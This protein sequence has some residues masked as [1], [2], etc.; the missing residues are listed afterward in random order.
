MIHLRADVGPADG[1]RIAVPD[2]WVEV[3][4]APETDVATTQVVTL[5]DWEPTQGLRPTMAVTIR[6]PGPEPVAMR[7]LVDAQARL[8]DVHVVSIDP[9]R[10]DGSPAVGRRLVFAHPA[11]DTTL[12]TLVWAVATDVGDVVVTAHADSTE[13]HR[14][15]AA[16]A[17]AVAGIRLPGA[18]ASSA[19]PAETADLARRA[20]GGLWEE[21][22]P[23]PR[24]PRAAI[25]ADPDA[26]ILVEAS[27]AGVGHRFDATLAGGEATVSATGSPRAD[28]RGSRV[29]PSAPP[30]TYRLPITRLGLAVA[31]WLGL[32]PAR[33]PSGDAV[34]LPIRLVMQRL[35]DPS[36][37]IPDGVD[38]A[39]WNQPWFLWTVRSSATD[40]GLVMVDTGTTGQC[41]VMETDDE[42]TTRF[43]PL[44][45]YN[46][47]L[48]LNWLISESR[49]A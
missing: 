23:T 30:A 8:P 13:L 46:V 22:A 19:A 31:Q 39:T 17:E 35:V 41:A 7:V 3:D 2:G 34:V 48:T 26:R 1:A 5:A 37:P 36:L 16:F 20:Q 45:S 44:S 21:V 38:S 24:V 6:P 10:V 9:W 15:D 11:G 25:V 43:A 28:A 29:V 47:W 40:S 27:V 14:Y 49:A 18:A 4:P 32:R 42:R 12:C 33:T